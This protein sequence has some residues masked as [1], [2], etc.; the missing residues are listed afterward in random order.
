MFPRYL[1]PEEEVVGYPILII[2]T[3]SAALPFGTVDYMGW[4]LVSEQFWTKIIMAKGTIDPKET[5][6]VP[7]M[8]LNGDLV[9]NRIKEFLHDETIFNFEKVYHLVDSST[10]LGYV[11]KECGAFHPFEG[12]HVAEIQLSNPFVNG[13]LLRWT[14]VSG[15]LNPTDWCTKPR[16]VEK[17]SH[18][19]FWKDRPEFLRKDESS[20]PI[21]FTFKTDQLEDEVTVV[22]KQNAFFQSCS[23]DIIGHLIDRCSVWRRIIR[24]FPWTL[25]FVTS[26][27]SGGAKSIVLSSTEI[28]KAKVILIKYVQKDM[29][30]DL[31]LAKEK[32][33][34]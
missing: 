11:N 24:V 22:K 3:N 21:K 20:W 28:Q 29:V 8:E 18:D 14:W 4:R 2:F 9:G 19:S 33:V 23:L 13:K 10:V 7:R 1:W 31:L 6:L 32:G 34:I 27:T 30:Q 5:L 17:V 25:R 16:S 26:E 12:R 15:A